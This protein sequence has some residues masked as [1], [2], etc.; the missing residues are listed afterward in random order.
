LLAA[1]GLFGVMA[2]AVAR[3]RREIGIRMAL[4]ATTRRVRG[5]VLR[6]SVLIV[7]A[8]LVVGLPAAFGLSRLVESMLYHVETHDKWS[9]LAAALLMLAIGAAAAWLPARRASR[10]DPMTALRC[11]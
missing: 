2:Y 3:R 5:M 1:V 4:G 9:F 8:G 6:E 7:L 10:V 11:E